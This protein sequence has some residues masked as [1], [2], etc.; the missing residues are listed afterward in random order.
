MPTALIIEDEALIALDLQTELQGL[1]IDVLGVAR[2]SAEALALLQDGDP[3]I[4][5]VDLML[6]GDSSGAGLADTLS[7][8]GVQ[9]LIVSGGDATKAARNG[10]AFLSKP[11]SRDDLSREIGALMAPA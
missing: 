6:N 11:W 5:I 2:T 9:I 1:G 3:D 8:R 4:A 10:H 7:A